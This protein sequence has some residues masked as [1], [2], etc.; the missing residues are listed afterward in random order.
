VQHAGVAVAA[1]ALAAGCSTGCSTV[2]FL[3]AGFL[4]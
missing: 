2:D 4:P 1:A 3:A